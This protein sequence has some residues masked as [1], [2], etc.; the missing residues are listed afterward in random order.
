MPIRMILLRQVAFLHLAEPTPAPQSPSLSDVAS[1][2]RLKR[3]GSGSTMITDRTLE[4]RNPTKH[5][6]TRALYVDL[7]RPVLSSFEAN[8][9]R[10]TDALKDVGRGGYRPDSQIWQTKIHDIG[11]AFNGVEANALDIEP[12]PG[13]EAT[14]TAFVGCV[15]QFVLVAGR[16]STLGLE[17]TQ[18]AA[19][20]ALL[21]VD[22]V[23][24]KCEAIRMTLEAPER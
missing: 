21:A 4:H 7:M 9:K 6:T 15:R 12:P 22:R 13:L 1:Q 18:E 24:E 16:A 2:I 20:E 23:K 3:D 5:P 10:F 11:A 17:Q 8:G 14:H 19:E